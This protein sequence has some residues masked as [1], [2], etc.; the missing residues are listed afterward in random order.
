MTCRCFA[1]FERIFSPYALYTEYIS[2]EL[3]SVHRLDNA[4]IVALNST[5][6]LRAITNG[7]IAS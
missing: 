3:D 6:P 5:A 7:R 2:K 1:S 4:V